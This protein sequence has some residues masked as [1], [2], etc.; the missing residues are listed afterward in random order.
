MNKNLTWKTILIIAITL[1]FVAGFTLGPDPGTTINVWKTQG[2]VAALQ[3]NIHLG[4]D[5]R[6]G[7][8]LILQVKVDDAVRSDASAS[9]DRLKS[10]MRTASINYS[11]V[12]QPD[13][14][15]HPDEI[16]VKGVTP[17]QRGTLLS[18]ISERLPDYTES[19]GPDG[20]YVITMKSGQLQDL[21]NRAVQQAI[22]TIRN[23]IDQ[24]GVSEPVIEEHGLGQYQILVQLPGVD[25]FERVKSLIQNTAMLDIRQVIS[26]PYASEQAA[27]DA[28]TTPGVLPPD[29]L[30]KKSAVNPSDPTMREPQWYVVSRS[31]AV[32]GRD[33][34]GA[35]PTTDE[36]GRPAVRFMLTGPGGQR[37]ASFTGAHIGDKLGVVLDDKVQEVA[38][39]QDRISDEGRITGAFTDQQAKDL[40]MLLRSGSLPA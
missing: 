21:K 36:N 1:V 7:M 33:L 23:R 30:L 6:G 22:E 32:T 17:D 20:S 8:H 10:E 2:F 38:T 35:E 37:F 27:M 24:L 26:G 19:P 13:P 14:Q 29:T 15:G 16:V 31:S 39:I 18:I 40:S 34:R 28:Q 12:S 9:M 11:D 25:D 5:L 4:L 3:Q